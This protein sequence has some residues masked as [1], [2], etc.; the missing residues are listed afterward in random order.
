MRLLRIFQQRS[1]PLRL[2]CL[3]ILSGFGLIVVSAGSVATSVHLENDDE[4][5]ASCHTNPEV[6]FVNRSQAEDPVDLASAHALFDPA[7][8][9][10]DCHSGQGT[11]GRIEALQQGAQDLFAYLTDDYAQPAVTTNPLGDDP[12]FKCHV[13]P[14]R[15]KP[16]DINDNPQIIA[17]NSHYHQIEYTEAWLDANADLAGTCGLCHPAHNNTTLA[18]L[19]FRH[20]PSVNATCDACHQDLSGMTP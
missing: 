1:W 8:R 5:C 3:L 10:I 20:M 16:V 17:S 18:A 12:C 6:S 9:C 7:V 2:S 15:D 19:G 13:Q 4:F 14:S 11:Q